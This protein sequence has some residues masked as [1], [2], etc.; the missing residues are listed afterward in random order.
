MSQYNPSQVNVPQL[1][2]RDFP[3]EGTVAVQGAV[4]GGD[5]DVL[6]FFCE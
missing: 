1:F 2:G 4:L 3:G 6:V 5:I